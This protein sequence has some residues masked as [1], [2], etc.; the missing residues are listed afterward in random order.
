MAA[1]AFDHCKPGDILYVEDT[2]HRYIVKVL[3][4]PV[5]KDFPGNTNDN[6]YIDVECISNNEKFNIG[7][8]YGCPT[9][10]KIPLTD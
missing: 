5:N 3:I 2:G 8:F 9:I 6:Y 4:L 7:G 10:Y 1:G